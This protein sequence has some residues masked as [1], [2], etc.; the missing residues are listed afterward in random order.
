M[1]N[2]KGEYKKDEGIMKLESKKYYNPEDVNCYCFFQPAS[3][4]PALTEVLET[5]NQTDHLPDPLYRFRA[6]R[7]RLLPRG[8]Q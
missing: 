2:S 6:P 3:S 4:L 1:Y 5:R 8:F 7:L